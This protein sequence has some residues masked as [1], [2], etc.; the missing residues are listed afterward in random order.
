[1]PLDLNLRLGGEAG[2]GVDTT[3]SALGRVFHRDGYHVFTSQDYMSRIRGG[4]NFY[5]IRVS[6]SPREAIRDEVDLLIALDQRT[7]DE[8][9]DALAAEGA[10]LAEGEAGGGSPET[11]LVPFRQLAETA[12]DPIYRNTV[13][14]GAALTLAGHPLQTFQALLAETFG[15][16]GAVVVAGNQQAAQAGA[17]YLRQHYPDRLTRRTPSLPSHGKILIGGVE[18]IALAGIA[19]GVQFYS[20]YPMTPSTGVLNYF[21]QHAERFGMVVEQAEDEIAAINLCLGASYAGARAMTATSGGGF[22]LMVEGLALAGMTETPVVVALGMRPGPATGLPTRT[23][24]GELWFALHAGH[25]E[26]PR[27]VFTPGNPEEAF[28]LTF[29]AF[30]LAG[31]YQTPALLLYDQ[32]LADMTMTVPRFDFSGL[33]VQRSLATGD[34][35]GEGYSYA[36]YRLTESGLSPRALPGTP[37]AVVEVDSDEHDEHGHII[38]D[39]ETRRA[40][41]D[42]RLRKYAGMRG[43]IVPPLLEGEESPDLLLLGWGSTRGCIAEATQILRQDGLRVARLHC[44]QLWPFPAQQVAAALQSAKRSVV[45]ENNAT[46]QFRDLIRRETGLQPDALVAKYDGRP[47]S[48]KEIVAAVSA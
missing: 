39:A 20:A 32:Y 28:Q 6:D 27:F 16:K 48:P 22:A 17:D 30:N 45:V 47:F 33:Q 40:M 23:E 36:R 34:E 10:I 19:A 43:E 31:G 12:G 15:R 29:R 44:P 24:Q 8:H 1:M 26:F 13:A 3:G 46:G 11:L 37:G 18:A 5:Q 7:L 14:A 41:V 42:K 25:G 21:A 9:R 2:L 38:E 4:H 35:V